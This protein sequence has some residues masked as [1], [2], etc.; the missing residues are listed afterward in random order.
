MGIAAG[1]KGTVGGGGA[2]DF[3]LRIKA[4]EGPSK[5]MGQLE[6]QLCARIATAGWSRGGSVVAHVPPLSAYH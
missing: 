4:P 6:V 1:C 5:M 2:S 3:A